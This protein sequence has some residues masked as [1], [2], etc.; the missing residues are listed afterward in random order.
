MVNIRR[1]PSKR[2]G[3]TL[4]IRSSP[5]IDNATSKKGGD[6]NTCG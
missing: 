1:A 2:Q 3:F 5:E 6:L 4:I